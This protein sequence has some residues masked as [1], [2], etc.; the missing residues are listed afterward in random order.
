MYTKEEQVAGLEHQIDGAKQV[1]AH[2]EDVVKLI[3]NPLF[4]KVIL[5]QFC[6]RDCARYVQ[7]SGDPLLSDSNRADALA[8]AQAAG[9]LRRWLDISVRIADNEQGRLLELQEELD[10]VR[11]EPEDEE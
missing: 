8:L 5:E 4:R 10:I 9:H 11:S 6:T 1:I 2:G 3:K 7:E